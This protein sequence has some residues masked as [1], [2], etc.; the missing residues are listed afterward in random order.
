M[1]FD[2]SYIDP[3]LISDY[4]PHSPYLTL[5]NFV[6]LMEMRAHDIISNAMCLLQATVEGE[7]LIAMI[8]SY[9]IIIN[10]KYVNQ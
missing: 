4:F 8:T 10:N 5:L 2:S 3:L 7:L 1:D 6:L 9:T